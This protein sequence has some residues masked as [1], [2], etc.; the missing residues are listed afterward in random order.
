MY[1]FLSEGTFPGREEEKEE[2]EENTPPM[3]MM[4]FKWKDRGQDVS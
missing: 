4:T 3:M 1:G 2:E